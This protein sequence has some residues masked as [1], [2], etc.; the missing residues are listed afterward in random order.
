M[1]YNITNRGIF[2]TH[3]NSS[4]SSAE[5]CVLNLKCIKLPLIIIHSTIIFILRLG[6]LKI[7]FLT[8]W[9]EWRLARLPYKSHLL[10]PFPVCYSSIHFCVHSFIPGEVSQPKIGGRRQFIYLSDSKNKNAAAF[11]FQRPP[12]Q[13]NYLRSENQ[14]PHSRLLWLTSGIPWTRLGEKRL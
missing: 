11:A 14:L 12:F 1:R 7:T 6:V 8:Q 10:P 9:D 13:E 5:A 4:F 2:S 3:L